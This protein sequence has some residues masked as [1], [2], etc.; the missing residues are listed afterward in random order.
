MTLCSKCHLNDATKAWEPASQA[1]CKSKFVFILEQ[2]IPGIEL[3]LKKVLR[4][5]DFTSDD[6]S[7][8]YATRCWE[9]GKKAAVH[10]I[11]CCK[12]YLQEWIDQTATEAILVP[13]GANVCKELLGRKVGSVHGSI[14]EFAGR[15]CVPTLHPLQVYVY[16]DSLPNFA[17]DLSKI[18]D[19]AQGILPEQ[20]STKYQACLQ[21]EEAI[22]VLKFFQRQSRFSFDIETTGLDPFAVDPLAKVV[23]INLSHKP[24]TGVTIPIDHHEAPWS[25]KE[26]D[27]IVA[28]LRETLEDPAARKFAHNGKFD[29]KYLKQ[30]LDI[31][32]Q[33]YCF[34]TMYAHYLAVTEEPGTHGL[35]T[36]AW[37]FTDMGGYD[38]PLEDY[39][40]K[41][42]EAETNYDLIPLDLLCSY[43][44]GDADCTIRLVDIFE[45]L[46][47]ADEGISS[48][49][50]NILMPAALALAKMELRGAYID[51]Q[52]LAV[53]EAEFK[54]L[55]KTLLNQLREFPEVIEA[56]RILTIR[57]KKK[58][59]QDKVKALTERGVRLD[60]VRTQFGEDSKRY[61]T[62]A[63]RLVNDIKVFKQQGVSVVPVKFTGTTEHKS[64]L[65]YTV[66]G[67]PVL[68]TT[69]K[70]QPS[71]DKE[72]M[73]ELFLETRNPVLKLLGALTKVRTL[74]DMFIKRMPERICQDGRLRGSF[75]PIGTVTGRLSSSGP[76][77][78]Q[79]PKN[80]KEDPFLDGLHVP[81]IKKLFTVAN[82]KKWVIMQFDYSQAELRVL[83]CLSGER[84]FIDAFNRGEDIH[85][86]TAADVNGIELEEVSDGQRGA[87]KA[88]N[89]GLLYGQGALKLAKTTRMELQ[90]A[91]DFIKLY[92]RK[93][94]RIQAY[95]NQVKA[96]VK[97]DGEIR[98]PFGR[99][100]RLATAFSPESDIVASAERQAVNSPIQ[101]A[102]SD[103]TLHA[104]I[105]ITRWLEA[106]W[107]KA[108]IS[109]T[110]HDSIILAVHRS[111]AAKVFT[112]VKNIMEHP[113]V[114]WL[115]VPMTADA[116]IGPSWGELTKVS[117]VAEV[118]EY[119]DK[120]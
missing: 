80:P 28:Q 82:P 105:R 120:S 17:K 92:F 36:L 91:K 25:R 44:A 95:I 58:A 119:L 42:P 88:V 83:A 18:Q 54:A 106:T 10:D 22:A 37:E 34:D 71:T 30:V 76:N 107:I 101:S 9:D 66:M 4:M 48:V 5:C 93:L 59:K 33:N 45:P 38:D 61:Q 14:L 90:Q 96:R 100:R 31:G 35:K 26:R 78:Q 1:F 8:L 111:Q 3:K 50:H 53:C 41:H 89:F 70:K 21:F 43:G 12:S 65:L 109:I 77:L 39:K 79:I 24:Y 55:M 15:I 62:M 85:K 64:V 2:P 46:V 19:A 117:S 108:Y 29:W 47:E 99:I 114:D 112:K 97:S 75:N 87:A 68:K 27:A 23:T 7:V 52:H 98:S 49:F 56:E 73:K 113:P 86:R 103:C 115:V 63:T 72:V 81:S 57:A 110:V 104:I 102:A 67:F 74:Y 20:T 40:T 118:E 84:T 51:Q 94:P 60:A 116:E 13:M 11:K 69:D 16:P 32:V 6:Y